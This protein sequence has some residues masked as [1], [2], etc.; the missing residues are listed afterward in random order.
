MRALSLK[1]IRGVMDQVKQ[2]P[3][4]LT[5]TPTPHPNRLSRGVMDQVKQAPRARAH[6]PCSRF[7]GRFPC[8]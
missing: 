7:A 3:S 2:A 5:L 4:T 6:A 8:D 1:L